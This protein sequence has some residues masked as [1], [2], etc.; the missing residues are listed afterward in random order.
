MAR[1]QHSFFATPS[2]L[3]ELLR[4]IEGAMHLRFVRTGLFDRPDPESTSSLRESPGLGVAVVGDAQREAG[5]LVMESTASLVVRPVVQRSGGTKYAIDQLENPTSI[6][7][8]P[9]G[10]F[11]ESAVISGQVG[12]VSEDPRSVRLFRLVEKAIRGRFEKIQ[13]FYVGPGAVA[14]LDRGWRLTTGMKSPAL[15]DLRRPGA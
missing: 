10:V 5:Y 11:G 15:Y 12:T 3:D 7:L 1:R 9:G 2:D 8:R 4:S 6:F 14:L 13:S